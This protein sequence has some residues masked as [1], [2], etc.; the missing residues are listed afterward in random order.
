MFDIGFMELLLVALIGLIVLG[1]ERL[2]KAAYTFGLMIARVRRSFS[3]VQQELEREVRM[4]E[5]KEKMQNPYA[6]FMD[7]ELQM[8]SKQ[9]KP[10]VHHSSVED[11][12]AADL[13]D[14]LPPTKA[15]PETATSAPTA[16]GTAAA[17]ESSNR[18]F[19]SPKE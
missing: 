11:E 10:G 5:L 16:L 9:Q 6:T 15:H 17:P 18:S 2:P 12:I 19:I 1:P 14:S 13:A 3:Q 7:D 4:Q 8:T